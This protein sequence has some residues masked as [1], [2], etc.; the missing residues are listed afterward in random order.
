MWEDNFVILFSSIKKK[1]YKLL[2][3]KLKDYNLSIIEAIYLIILYDEKSLTFK[4]LTTKADCDKGM[5]TK[6]LVKLK[7]MGYV[8][9]N[10]KNIEIT[11]KGKI[12]GTK[13][14]NI[15]KELRN[16]LNKKIGEKELKNIYNELSN[17]NNILEGE[18]KC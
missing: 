2:N 6:V 13:I 4:E 15:L 1:I 14:K 16:N 9:Y 10:I 8:T 12:T 3:N 11:D 17:F 5:T 18:L 7:M